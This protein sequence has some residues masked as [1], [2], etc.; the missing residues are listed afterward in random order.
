[1]P[2]VGFL[3]GSQ[4]LKASEGSTVL[5]TQDGSPTGLAVDAIGWRSKQSLSPIR[6]LNME[7]EFEEGVH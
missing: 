1:M 4:M 2:L 5:D 3:I 6:G 7:A